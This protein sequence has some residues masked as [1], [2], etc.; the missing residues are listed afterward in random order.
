MAI[1]GG[2]PSRGCSACRTRNLGVGPG[3]QGCVAKSGDVPWQQRPKAGPSFSVLSHCFLLFY[4]R[5]AAGWRRWSRK[6]VQAHL[7]YFKMH[8]SSAITSREL[9][10]DPPDLKLSSVTAIDRPA[11]ADSCIPGTTQ[12]PPRCFICVRIARNSPNPER[13]AHSSYSHT[14]PRTAPSVSDAAQPL[15]KPTERP[16]VPH[17]SGPVVDPPSCCGSSTKDPGQAARKRGVPRQQSNT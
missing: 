16:V 3:V 2:G 4:D 1:S 8:I 9:P 10:K 5:M 11:A 12:K 13:H 6:R 15:V 7:P 14:N 17:L